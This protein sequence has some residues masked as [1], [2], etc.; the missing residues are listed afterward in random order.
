MVRQCCSGY[1]ESA[2]AF[3]E[4]IVRRELT[5]YSLTSMPSFIGQISVQRSVLMVRQYG[6]CYKESA[7][8]DSE[9]I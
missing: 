5:S 8:A 9:R 7:K 4:F 2:K 1:K 6:S 3:I